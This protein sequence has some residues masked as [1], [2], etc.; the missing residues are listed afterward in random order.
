[1]KRPSPTALDQTRH[2]RAVIRRLSPLTALGDEVNQLMAAMGQGYDE[3]AGHYGFSCQ[4]CEESCCFTVFYHHTYAEFLLLD[5][6][7]RSLKTSELDEVY[8]R[9][10]KVQDHLAKWSLSGAAE[11]PRAMCPLNRAGRC[12]LYAFRPMI[13]RLHGI[14]HRLRRPDGRAISGP[15]CHQFEARCGEAASPYLDRTPFYRRLAQVEQMVRQR[16]QVPMRLNM[17][18][19]EWLSALAVLSQTDDSPAASAP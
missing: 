3:V 19:A 11:P 2:L 18:L 17:T 1:M 14:P 15:G 13:C 7:L 5:Q 16:V 10:R 9:A 4:G 12:R 6:G 8:G